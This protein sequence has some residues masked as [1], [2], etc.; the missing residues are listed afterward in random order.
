MCVLPAVQ[1]DHFKFP[2][3]GTIFSQLDIDDL[4][5][6]QEALW[7]ARS[8]WYNIGIRLKVKDSD[9]EC[10]NAVSGIEVGEKFTQMLRTRLKMLEPVTWEELCD[11]LNHLIVNEPTL[12]RKVKRKKI[13]SHDRMCV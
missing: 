13:G 10:I 3:K 8:K 2:D 9:L 6:V 12:A 4:A 5:E 11:T 1:L 7:E